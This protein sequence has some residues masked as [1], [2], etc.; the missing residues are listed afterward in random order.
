[1]A[2]GH[3]VDCIAGQSWESFIKEK[4]FDVLG[5]EKSNFSFFKSRLSGNFAECYYLKDD[6]LKQYKMNKEFDP[7]HIFPGTPAGGINSTANEL[8]K[9]MI[10]Q[11]NKGEYDGKSIVSEKAFAEM[12]SPQMIDNWNSPYEEHGEFSCG[13]GWFIWRYRGA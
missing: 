8:A 7:E 3:L 4:I 10:L 2:A 5:M 9:W 6:E 12:H 13:L 1:M 11:L